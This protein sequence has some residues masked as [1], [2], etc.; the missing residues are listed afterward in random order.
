MYK[1]CNRELCRL[2]GTFEKTRFRSYSE[3]LGTAERV[4]AN[5]SATTLQAV[6]SL[7]KVLKNTSEQ[8]VIGDLCQKLNGL[9]LHQDESLQK[10]LGLEGFVKQ[11]AELATAV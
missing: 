11:K 1:N 6:G 7:N 3:L 5:S 4:F 2:S 9:E 10:V 8:A